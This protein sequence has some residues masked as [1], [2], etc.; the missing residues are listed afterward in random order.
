MIA[1]QYQENSNITGADRRYRSL[2]FRAVGGLDTRSSVCPDAEC[3]PLHRNDI[4]RAQPG[5]GDQQMRCGRARR[6]A[7][8]GSDAQ[9]ARVGAQALSSRVT[10]WADMLYSD[11]RDV[12]QAALPGQTFVLI[13][14]VNPFFR[15]PPGTGSAFGFFD[16]RPDRLVGDDH[17]DQTYR[18]RAGNSSAG[19][20]VDLPDLFRSSVYGT[21]NW[22]RN[23]TF[24]PRINTAALD[25]G[26]DGTTTATALDPFGTGTSPAV[27]AAITRLPDGLHQSQRVAH[28]RGQDRRAAGRRFPADD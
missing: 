26:G 4:R 23:D 14:A 25:R 10:L 7:A 13:T 12:V 18:V 6:P 1:Y 17:F 16:F 22:S 3:K 9:P 21:F 19:V 8:A 5:A 20:D 28:R 11:R 2:D 24:Q 15:A 27:A